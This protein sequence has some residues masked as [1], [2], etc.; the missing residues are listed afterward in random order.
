MFRVQVVLT[1]IV[2]VVLVAVTGYL[3]HQSAL[4]EAI[5]QDTDEALRRAATVAELDRRVQEATL[6]AKAQFI[7]RGKDLSDAILADYAAPSP[8]GAEEGGEEEEAADGDSEEARHERHLKVYERLLRYQKEFELYAQKGPGK[9]ARQIDLPM[10]WR[11]P[12][13]PDL[14]FAVDKKGISLAA[15]GKDL[16]KWYDT[17]VSKDYPLVSEVLV[18]KEVRTAIWRWSFDDSVTGDERPL[19]LVALAPIRTSRDAEPV[20]VVVVGSLI[21][22]GAAKR[23]QRALAGVA[24]QGLDDAERDRVMKSAPALAYYHGERVVGST[25]DANRQRVIT[26]NLKQGLNLLGQEGLEK[27]GELEIDEET[28]LVRARAMPG[29]GAAKAT[30]GI[31]VLANLT[32]AQKPLRDPGTYT[33]LV[34]VMV[35]LI[36]SVLMLLF[37]QVFLRPFEGI[38]GGIQEIIAGNK[39]Y[40]FDYNGKNKMARGLSQ[41]LNLMSAFLQGKPMPDDDEGGNWGD[42]NPGG[43]GSSGGGGGPSR[44]QGVSMADLMGKKPGASDDDS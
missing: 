5:A 4:S 3:S 32:Q 34:A 8:E 16:L 40:S 18:K 25:L 29:K 33:I 13:K 24:E 14:F 10:Q 37:I 6:V 7:A 42:L 1:F 22:D 43:G 41:Q 15:L 30:S 9:G 20:G 38:E 31:V 12:V 26:Q 21:N 23:A 44:V 17:D 11:Q 35:A 39:D 28:Y 27:S 2:C 19:Y 36:G